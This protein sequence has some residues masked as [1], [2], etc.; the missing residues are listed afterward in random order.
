MNKYQESLKIYRD[1]RN[2]ME[3]AKKEA[4]REGREAGMEEGRKVGIKE[5]MYRK[6]IEIA[7]T[8]KENGASVEL[9]VKSTGLTLEQVK[10]L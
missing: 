10:Q 9:I 6:Q 4:L 1:N 5:G 8:L 2:T 3:Y 7:K